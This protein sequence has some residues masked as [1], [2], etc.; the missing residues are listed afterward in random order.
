MHPFEEFK[1]MTDPAAKIEFGFELLVKS[2]QG[3]GSSSRGRGAYMNC[4]EQQIHEMTMLGGRKYSPEA[5]KALKDFSKSK[6][7]LIEKSNNE[8][9]IKKW[10]TVLKIID[11]IMEHVIG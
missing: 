6:V 11:P 1:D 4:I 10:S 5:E 7:N 2:V 3:N 9:D 8:D